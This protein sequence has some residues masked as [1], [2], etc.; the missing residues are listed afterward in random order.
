MYKGKFNIFDLIQ[1]IFLLQTVHF[2]QLT[3]DFLK[4]SQAISNELDPHSH[5][6]FF[7]SS[8]VP[9]YLQPKKYK[10]KFQ[11]IP[12]ITT[13]THMVH[14]FNLQINFTETN[15]AHKLLKKFVLKKRLYTYP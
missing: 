13:L 8:K 12:S 3:W 14:F 1:C 5:A 4:V 9:T 6:C 7:T 2:L 11:A 10:G 15:S